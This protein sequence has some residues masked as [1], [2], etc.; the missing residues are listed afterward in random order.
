MRAQGW[1]H[2]PY[3]IHGDRWFSDGKATRLVRDMGAESYDNPPSGEP[4][5]P[6]VPVPPPP[7]DNT[8]SRQAD[9]ATRV[10]QA[11]DAKKA[12]VKM[13]D[14]ILGQEPVYWMVSRSPK[15]TGRS[16]LCRALTGSSKRQQPHRPQV[17]KI[18]P[19]QPPD[20]PG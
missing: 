2:D 19:H 3:G 14:K 12:W 1:F 4:V 8:D 7:S 16:F 6:L 11:Y 5:E 17:P 9:A 20:L 13:Q 18:A 15:S 10:D